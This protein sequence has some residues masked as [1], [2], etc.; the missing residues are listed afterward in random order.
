MHFRG[1]YIT[2]TSVYRSNYIGSF[3][4]LLLFVIGFPLL[5]LQDGGILVIFFD[6]F[7]SFAFGAEA[8]NSDSAAD[9]IVSTSRS[10]NPARKHQGS[11]RSVPGHKALS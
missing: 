9:R 6:N 8:A 10:E 5:E 11:A 3:I 4:R 1:E 7:W 2:F